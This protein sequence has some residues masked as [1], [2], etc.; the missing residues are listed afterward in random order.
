MSL[1]YFVD[2]S[3][4]KPCRRNP[5]SH[6]RKMAYSRAGAGF[7][8]HVIFR[9]FAQSAPAQFSRG[10]CILLMLDLWG[11][12]LTATSLSLGV[13]FYQFPIQDLC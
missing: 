10:I 5:V 3:F 7:R 11:R 4:P 9:K 13:S 12:Q 2:L 6:V 1:G 8:N